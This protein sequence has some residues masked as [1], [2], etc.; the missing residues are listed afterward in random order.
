MSKCLVTGG[1]GFIGSHLVDT[2][3]DMGHDVVVIDN[4]SAD[5]EKFYWNNKAR[6]YVRDICD[7]EYIRP[8]FNGVD[9]VFH[10]AAESRLPKAIENP[11]DATH[12]NVTGTCTVLQCARESGVEK[13]IYSSTSS[14]Y[15]S[16]LEVNQEYDKRDC[17]NP[18]SATKAAGEDLCSM[19][20]KM[21][22]LKTI[23]LRYFSVY[24]ERMPDFG[25]Y[26]LVT[27]IFMK[28]FKNNEPLTITG[29]GSQTRD[30]IHVKDVALANIC[31]AETEIHDTYYGT[32]F[33]VATGKDTSVLELADM[34]SDNHIFIPVRSGESKNNI[35]NND[36][37][38][39]VLGWQST[40]N[41]QDWINS[42][43][44]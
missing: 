10:L 32:A 42:V 8:L 19:Y 5:N 43:K 31:A 17:L 6:N 40:I 16:S 33:N 13:V 34:I 41:L 7:Y 22:G 39:R 9:Y 44:Q 26:A 25:Q 38:K 36:K 3:I 23:I 35:A 27:G 2:L 24:G 15:G 20:T 30:F 4:C 37:I 18:Y 1:A 12:R 28:Q 29:D 14:V 21:Y 11:I